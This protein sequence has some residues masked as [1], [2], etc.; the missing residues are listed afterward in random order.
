MKT[1]HE[2][3]RELLALPDVTVLHFDPSWVVDEESPNAL[4]EPKAELSTENGDDE[5][6]NPYPP[7]ICISG[8]PVI[9]GPESDDVEVPILRDLYN[10]AD[11]AMRK[12]IDELR[13]KHIAEWERLRAYIEDGCGDISKMFDDDD[14]GVEHHEFP[15]AES[16]VQS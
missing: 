8:Q 16:E 2:F 3:A 14:D 11:E 5:D 6:G 15:R 10:E 9:E 4:T 7:F 12:H 13:E 1:A